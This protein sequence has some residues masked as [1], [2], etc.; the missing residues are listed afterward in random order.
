MT[1]ALQ[2]QTQIELGRQRSPQTNVKYRKFG[3]GVV[4]VSQDRR[5][6]LCGE[7]NSGRGEQDLE[8][9]EWTERSRRKKRAFMGR[10]LSYRWVFLPSYLFLFLFYWWLPVKSLIS[11][12]IADYF[13]FQR[14]FVQILKLSEYTFSLILFVNF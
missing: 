12:D 10:F 5:R 1:R 2:S 13:V 3:R 14:S 8:G 4:S 9:S 7:G 11:S 6:K